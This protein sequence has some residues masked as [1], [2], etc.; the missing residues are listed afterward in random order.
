MPNPHFSS[1]ALPLQ[2]HDTFR[3]ESPQRLDSLATACLRVLFFRW[4]A[5]RRRI[6]GG[7]RLLAG[8]D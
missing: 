8:A 7:P 6:P 1:E 2:H 5:P 4:V 3:G